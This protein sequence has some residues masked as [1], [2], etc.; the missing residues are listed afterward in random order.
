MYVYVFVNVYLHVCTYIC[1][2][3]TYPYF[4]VLQHKHMVTAASLQEQN[5]QQQQQQPT[6]AAT[7]QPRTQTPMMTAP[8]VT[9]E[10]A[11]T[12]LYNI[13]YSIDADNGGAHDTDGGREDTSKFKID[14]DDDDDDV[15]DV[16]DDDVDDDD[17]AR[18]R[19]NALARAAHF[20]RMLDLDDR[21]DGCGPVFLETQQYL[22][23]NAIDDSRS[24][25]NW[26]WEPTTPRDPLPAMPQA[27]S[28]PTTPRV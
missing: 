19:A 16:D 8:V 12:N 5:H 1:V 15:D 23:D 18:V 4:S 11:M 7:A 17:I 6:S 26:G 20:N 14:D 22:A 9:T 24:S 21:H 2:I 25:S 27:P 10:Q 13:P 28:E 3:F